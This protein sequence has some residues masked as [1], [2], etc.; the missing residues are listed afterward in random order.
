M[1]TQSNGSDFGNIVESH[2]AL[3]ELYRAPHQ[4]V[5]NKDTTVLDQG[6][7]DFLARS[8]LVLVST[9][10]DQGNLITE[11]QLEQI[12]EE[13]YAADLAADAPETGAS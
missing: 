6:C 12:L 5:L 9:V 4:L 11:A 1:T 10:D 3:G 8:T 13:G 7:R 2:E